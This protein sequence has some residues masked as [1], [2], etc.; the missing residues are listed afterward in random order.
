MTEAAPFTLQRLD[1]VVLRTHD[2]D[3]LVAFYRAL[4]CSVVREVARMHMVQLAAGASMIDIIGV[5]TREPGR[6][7]DHFALRIEPYDDER[8]RSFCRER[9]IEIEIPEQLLLGAD[10]FGPA[11]YLKDPDGNRV[12]LKGPPEKPR[13]GG[14][15]S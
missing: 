3:R 7:L 6:N 11:V 8:I 10:G 14:E 2:V 9:G 13:P 15:R 12:E 5:Q 4:G 1:H